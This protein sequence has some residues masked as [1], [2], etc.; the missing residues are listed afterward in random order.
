M[1]NNPDK[2]HNRMDDWDWK[3]LKIVAAIY[4]LG[5]IL[6]LTQPNRQLN[7]KDMPKEQKGVTEVLT[8][9]HREYMEPP[10]KFL[11]NGIKANKKIR[12]VNKR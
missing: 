4:G 3:L 12:I 5:A 2:K 6:A 8:S 11:V 1:A 10:R 7:S 9:E